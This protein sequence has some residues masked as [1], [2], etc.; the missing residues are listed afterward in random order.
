M[1]AKKIVLL[2]LIAGV[3]AAGAFASGNK[4]NEPARPDWRRAPQG[5]APEFSE[6]TV[7]VTG[8]LYFENRMHPE[9]KSGTKEYELLVPHFYAYELDLQDGQT[10]TVEGYT[11]EGMPCYEEEDDE[12]IH[13]WVTKAVIDGE[14]YDLERGGFRGGHMDPRWGMGPGMAPRGGMMGRRPYG[15][16]DPRDWG[17]RW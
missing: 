2:L 14:E 4:E 12:E 9:L 13:I 3:A 6:E 8:Q 1:N 16:G 15:S 10:I 17:R 11:V 5:E 7:T